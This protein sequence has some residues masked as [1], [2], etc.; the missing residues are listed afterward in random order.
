M[1]PDPREAND[2]D[3]NVRMKQADADFRREILLDAVGVVLGLVLGLM[4]ISLSE[5]LS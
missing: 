2:T 3:F 4:I 1:T 5:W